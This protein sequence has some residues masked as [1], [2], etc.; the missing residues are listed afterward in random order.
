MPWL[1]K[2]TLALTL[3]GV[4]N[5]KKKRLYKGQ[6]ALKVNLEGLGTNGEVWR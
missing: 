1:D 5:A 3:G 6:I 4:N 2:K